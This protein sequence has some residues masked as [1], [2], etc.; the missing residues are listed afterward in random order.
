MFIC[1]PINVYLGFFQLS[2]L[3]MKA[4]SNIYIQILLCA[5]KAFILTYHVLLVFVVVVWQTSRN[6]I[7]GS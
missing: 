7:A 3:M 6:G 1:P 4:I 5:H 2:A